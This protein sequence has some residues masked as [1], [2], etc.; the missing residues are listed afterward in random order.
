MNQDFGFGIDVH[1]DGFH[2]S[3]GQ[4]LRAGGAEYDRFAVLKHDAAFRS[5]GPRGRVREGVVV[6][7]ATVLQDFDKGAAAMPSRSLEHGSEV[8][9]ISRQGAGDEGGLS[10]EGSLNGADG[11]LN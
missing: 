3:N 10:R 4:S 7:D 2:V 8:I 1:N 9:R 11:L 6:E 5:L